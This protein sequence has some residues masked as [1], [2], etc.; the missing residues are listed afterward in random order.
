[1]KLIF[2]L[3]GITLIN[4]NCSPPIPVYEDGHLYIESYCSSTCDTDRSKM[5]FNCFLLILHSQSTD[6][7]NITEE[8]RNHRKKNNDNVSF[9]YAACMQK[10]SELPK[11][12]RNKIF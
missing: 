5:E 11:W 8:E 3:I 2:L 10:A 12:P 6:S 7:K 4:S 9:A 1:M